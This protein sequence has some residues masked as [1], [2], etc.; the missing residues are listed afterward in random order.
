[1]MLTGAVIGGVAG[2]IVGIVVLALTDGG[3]DSLAI[4]DPGAPAAAT[5]MLAAAFIVGAL[6]GGVIAYL[7]R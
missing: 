3:G 7:R 5:L 6:A 1:M 2:L 4:V